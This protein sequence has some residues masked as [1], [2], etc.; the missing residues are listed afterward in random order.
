MLLL[1]EPVT[2]LDPV[3]SKDFY[4]LIKNLNQ[5]E[6]ITILMISHNVKDAIQDAT[7]VLHLRQK[8]LFFGTVEE[9]RESK[10]GMQFLKE[11]EKND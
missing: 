2:G 11:E 4:H 7:H 8:Q 1:D 3:V 5:E 10:W 9:Y 6:K